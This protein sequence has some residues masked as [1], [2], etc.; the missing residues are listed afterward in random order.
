[1]TFSIFYIPHSSLI[2]LIFTLS[3]GEEF[4]YQDNHLYGAVIVLPIIVV[5]ECLPM[6]LVDIIENVMDISYSSAAQCWAPYNQ[7]D[8]FYVN[9]YKYPHTISRSSS[10]GR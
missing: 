9:A 3:V 6:A 7:Y 2:F 8:I 1:M 5:I 4:I 10:T